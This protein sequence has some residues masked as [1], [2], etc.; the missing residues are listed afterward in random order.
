MQGGR[1]DPRQF[2]GDPRMQGGRGERPMS[3]AEKMMQASARAA[4]DKEMKAEAAL[5]ART[6]AQQQGMPDGVLPGFN[7]DPL[8]SMRDPGPGMTPPMR[9]QR[10]QEPW[11]APPPDAGRPPMSPAERMLQNARKAAADERA[12]EQASYSADGL[13]PDSVVPG[14]QGHVQSQMPLSGRHKPPSSW[15]Q[16][17]PASQRDQ[18]REPPPLRVP[19]GPPPQGGPPPGSPAARA[20]DLAAR[21]AAEAEA[22]ANR[23]GAEST[24]RPDGFNPTGRGD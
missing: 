9:S 10:P 23:Q 24:G 3:P 5:R 6:M 12:Q 18:W 8:S 7:G 21:A 1:G 20:R 11:S 4:A 15:S 2:G 19:R 16:A 14:L 22:A 17:A 13:K